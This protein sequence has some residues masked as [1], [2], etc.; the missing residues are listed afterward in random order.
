LNTGGFMNAWFMKLEC[1]LKSA[2]QCF[3]TILA[4]A[5]G[6]KNRSWDLLMTWRAEHH[7]LCVETHWKLP[8]T[9]TSPIDIAQMTHGRSNHWWQPTRIIRWMTIANNMVE[10]ERHPS[11]CLPLG[12]LTKLR[13][14][15]MRLRH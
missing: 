15:E 9:S 6:V 13:R 4:L 8:P 5:A 11:V 14:L 2:G 10:M 1:W 3:S 7:K 12:A